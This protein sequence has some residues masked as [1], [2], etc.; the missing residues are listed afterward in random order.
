MSSR[1]ALPILRQVVRNGRRGSCL[2]SS[3]YLRP[4]AVATGVSASSRPTA[5]SGGR[6]GTYSTTPAS[7]IASGEDSG[8]GSHSDFAPQRKAAPDDDDD[9][10]TQAMIHDHVTSNPIMLYMKGTPSMPMC[11]FSARVV[12]VLQQEGVNFS[13]VNVLDY[14][15]IREGVKKYAEWPTIPQLYVGGEFVGGCDIVLSRAE[16]G[17]LSDLL[18]EAVAGEG[19]SK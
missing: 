13:S 2:P 7:L 19:E 17:E 11:G 12:G 8:D 10:A 1:I 5:E 4:A 18:K 15:S 6:I 9:A 14:P 3:S 16:S